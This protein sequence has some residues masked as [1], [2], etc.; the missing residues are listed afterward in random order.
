M[1]RVG[2]P[3]ARDRAALLPA[4]VLGRHAPARD[5]RD[6]AVLLARAADRRR[7]DHRARRHDP[8]ADPR[9]AAAPARRDR[10]G[11]HPG[12]PR[13]RRRRR[14]RRPRRRHVRRADRRA[15][16]RWTRSSTTRSTRTPG[17]CSARSPGSTATAPQRLPAIPGLP[18]SLLRPADGLPFPP[19]LPARVRAL[20]RG[21]AARGARSPTRPSISIAAGSSVEEQA[22]AARRSATRSGWPRADGDLV[23]VEVEPQSD[24]AGQPN[25]APLLE[26]EHL[27]AATSRSSRASLIDRTV[28]ARP[29][30][31]RRVVRA[32][33]GRDARDRR[34][35]GLR[36]D[37]ADP[38]AGAAARADRRHDP[39][40]RPR[41]HAAPAARSS[42][43][44]AAR[45][46][47]SSRTRS[48]VAEPAQARRP[49][50]RHAAAAPRRRPK[51]GSRPRR[52]SCSTR[53]GSTPSTSTASRT[54]SPAVSASASASPARWRSS[55]KLIVLDE[56][57][58]ALDVSIQAQVDQPAR[59]A[60][61]RASACPTCSSPTT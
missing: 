6:G 3:R 39:L 18:P 14:H 60:P 57:V 16:R 28:G 17:G 41:H 5:D 21:A 33:R 12:H 54:S 37:D 8:G 10:R 25:G 34:R 43:R 24:R 51:D 58:S 59:R 11:D 55:P 23:S 1:E 40:P 32:A 20:H 46:R 26:V 27:A 15:G 45:C 2:I 35:V 22:H 42:R 47:W 56:P 50:H 36:Q 9:R 61:G 19:A 29:R 53:S 52:A 49:D 4:R 7:A 13:P 44:S 30:R 38:H 31:R 48:R